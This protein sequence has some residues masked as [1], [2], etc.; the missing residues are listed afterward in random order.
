MGPRLADYDLGHLDDEKHVPPAEGVVA[1]PLPELA[2]PRARAILQALVAIRT[3][4]RPFRCPNLSAIR[5][6][7]SFFNLVWFAEMKVI[8]KMENK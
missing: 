4:A 2:T 5:K 6:R 3:V 8:V 1:V 7:R